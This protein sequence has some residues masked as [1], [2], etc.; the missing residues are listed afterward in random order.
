VRGCF[1]LFL[2]LMIGSWACAAYGPKAYRSANQHF[3]N[4]IQTQEAPY[5]IHYIW[6]EKASDCRAEKKTP[7]QTLFYLDHT[8][9]LIRAA[10]SLEKLNGAGNKIAID[11]TAA[12]CYRLYTEKNTWCAVWVYRANCKALF[13]A[14]TKTQAG[15]R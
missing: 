11:F 1:N 14:T 9:L 7:D 2:L 6:C 12:G 13:T 3:N 10:S 4:Q 5:Q 8:Y 15:A